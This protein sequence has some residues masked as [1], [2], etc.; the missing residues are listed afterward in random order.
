MPYTPR[1]QQSMQQSNGRIRRPFSSLF[2]RDKVNGFNKSGPYGLR[3]NSNR[4]YKFVARAKTPGN[5]VHTIMCYT[6]EDVNRLPPDAEI[7]IVE[8]DENTVSL[9]NSWCFD[10]A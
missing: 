1:R 8:V 9:E 10:L 6:E 2:S 4:R 3:A 5:T 7:Y